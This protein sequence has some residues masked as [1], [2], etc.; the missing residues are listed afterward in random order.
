MTDATRR[1]LSVRADRSTNTPVAQIQRIA[2]SRRGLVI[3]SLAIL[4]V[5]AFASWDWLVAAGLAPVLIAL[6]PCLAMCG[7]GM[8][9]RGNSCNKQSDQSIAGT[10]SGGPERRD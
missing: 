1:E 9:M 3:G 5:G 2:L 6:G 7:L 8:C 10:G 4:G